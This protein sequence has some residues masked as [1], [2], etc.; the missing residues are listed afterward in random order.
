MRIYPNVAGLRYQENSQTDFGIER[1][2]NWAR[3]SGKLYDNDILISGDVDEILYPETL[4]LLRWCEVGFNQVSTNHNDLLAIRPCHICW[5]LD[6][7]WQPW[8]GLPVRLSSWAKYT[9]TSSHMAV[10]N[11]LQVGGNCNWTTRWEKKLC[12]LGCDL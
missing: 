11:H 9:P 2:K 5:S 1:V 10:T 6:A 8:Q 7:S 4:N 3:A 12:I